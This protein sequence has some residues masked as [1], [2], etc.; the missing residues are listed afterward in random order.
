MRCRDVSGKLS[1]FLDEE[2]S[3]WEYRE[4]ARHLEACTSCRMEYEKL[5]AVRRAVRELGKVVPREIPGTGFSL[6]RAMHTLRFRGIL[7]AAVILFGLLA[8][9]FL[10]LGWQR[11]SLDER[12][13]EPEHFA[14]FTEDVLTRTRVRV[15]TIELVSGDY[16]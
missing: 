6:N 14:A 3:A 10:V 13:L 11:S 1:A 8:T 12:I 16:R 15:E 7:W 9:I 2:L 4:V 5:S